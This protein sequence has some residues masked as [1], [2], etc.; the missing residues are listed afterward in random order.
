[1]NSDAYFG[2]VTEICG[3]FRLATRKLRRILLR[4]TYINFMAKTQK[5]ICRKALK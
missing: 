4:T 3:C 1:M 5:T 2:V